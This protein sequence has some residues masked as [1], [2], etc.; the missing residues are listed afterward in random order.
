[1]RDYAKKDFSVPKREKQIEENPVIAFFACC[2]MGA[3][4]GGLIGYGLL[5][6]G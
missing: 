5:F 1:M 6:T 4:L 3:V 2:F